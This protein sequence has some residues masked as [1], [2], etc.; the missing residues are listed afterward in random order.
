MTGTRS[1]RVAGTA[2]AVVLVTLAVTVTAGGK[3]PV[4]AVADEAPAAGPRLTLTGMTDTYSVP[5][6]RLPLR[7]H[8]PEEYRITLEVREARVVKDVEVRIDLPVLAGR[9]DITRVDEGHRCAV[10]GQVMTC[11]LGDVE[12][13]VAFTPFALT[14]RQGAAPGPAGALTIT[15]TSADTPTVRHT[16]RVVVG[17]PAAQPASAPAGRE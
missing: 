8:L 4:A 17:A 6:Y 7:D 13:G 1:Q 11:A 10:A 3:A 15:V 16:T 5:P 2:A 14:P 12:R 9:A